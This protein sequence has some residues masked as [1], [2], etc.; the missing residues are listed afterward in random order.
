MPIAEV[1]GYRRATRSY[2]RHLYA[3]D[4]SPVPNGFEQRIGDTSIENILHRLLAEKM[5]E[6]SVVRSGLIFCLLHLGVN[7]NLDVTGYGAHA[8][9]D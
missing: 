4:I 3:E 9:V 8:F 7:R 6:N 2:D 5:V 1:R